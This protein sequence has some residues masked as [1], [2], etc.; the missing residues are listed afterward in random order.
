MN[1]MF[2]FCGIVIAGWVSPDLAEPIAPMPESSTAQP[3]RPQAT[4]LQ[5][6]RQQ[7][8]YSQ[9]AGTRPA[10]A[11]NQGSSRGQR[12][13]M[14][15][16]DPRTFSNVDLPMPPTMNDSGQLPGSGMAGNGLNRDL[17]G[18]SENTS[19]RSNQK[20]FANYRPGPT[21]SPYQLLDSTTDNG[22]VNS[23]TNYVRPAEERQQAQQEF[24]RTM[25]ND[26]QPAP[27]Y[28]RAFLNYGSYYPGYGAGR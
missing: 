27:V 25:S 18:P 14:A 3:S 12:M 21:T 11:M 20:A 7:P 10:Q 17:V 16:T 2:A 19:R 4:R 24:D 6:S 28:P 15:P 26:D 22:T 1:A 5:P 13:P 8:S 23:Y 9:L